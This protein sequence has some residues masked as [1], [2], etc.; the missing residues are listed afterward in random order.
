MRI[1]SAV[2]LVTGAADDGGEDGPGGVISGEASLY[3]TGAI[4]AHKGGSFLFLTHVG[5]CQRGGGGRRVQ[6][7]ES[8]P[9]RETCCVIYVLVYS[10]LVSYKLTQGVLIFRNYK[11][12]LLGNKE[13]LLEHEPGQTHASR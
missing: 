6:L 3:K 1:L 9:R 12:N 10:F 13:H 4:V 7:T 5:F 11:R 8:N 2:Y